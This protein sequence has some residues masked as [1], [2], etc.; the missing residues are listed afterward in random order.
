MSMEQVANLEVAVNQIRSQGLTSNRRLNRNVRQSILPS[1]PRAPTEGI[2]EQEQGIMFIELKNGRI[3]VLYVTMLAAGFVIGSK[4]ISIRQICEITQAQI[5]SVTLQPGRF[6]RTTRLFE[7]S[8]TQV[9][10]LKALNI[11]VAGVQLY[12][13][14]TEGSMEGQRVEQ[15]QYAE[16]V[17][18][19]YQ[20]PPH[21]L[22]PQAA[23]LIQ[24]GNV[25][26]F[27]NQQV[28]R[29]MSSASCYSNEVGHVSLGSSFGNGE[30]RRVSSEE[31][32]LEAPQLKQLEIQGIY[33]R[34]GL[35]RSS[36]SDMFQVPQV[37]PFAGVQEN[38]V[39]P[40]MLNSQPFI[41][42][43]VLDNLVSS[44]QGMPQ[45]MDEAVDVNV[46]EVLK[47]VGNVQGNLNNKKATKQPQNIQQFGSINIE[48][49]E[50][51][52]QFLVNILKNV[53]L[54]QV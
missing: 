11:I 18:F 46:L 43:E 27:A 54:D 45:K 28:V 13:T 1:G 42:R 32:G 9:Q 4:G 17:A 29:P 37:G 41:G 51:M 44:S 30:I 6:P 2:D 5:R 36:S 23:Q 35:S 3:V 15:V 49:D 12:K 31:I 8:G 16:G 7:I 21:R 53:N 20:P 47:N 39:D 25:T 26:L 48:Q 22:V 34:Q 33:N 24:Q 50:N 14:L 10:C 38:I 40:S 19:V 52:E